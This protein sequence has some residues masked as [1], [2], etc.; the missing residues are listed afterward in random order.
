[1]A[2]SKKPIHNDFF[3]RQFS[4]PEFAVSFFQNHLPKQVAD[5]VDWGNFRLAS[6]DFVSKALKNRKSD[7]LYETTIEDRKSLFYL[8]LEHQRK[9]HKEM[10]FR[11]L[12]YWLHILERHKRQYPKQD[13]PLIFP[14]VLYQGKENWHVAS[15]FHDYLGVPQSLKPYT[16]Q[17]H[18]ALVD[19]SHL[20]DDEI[21]GKLL[22]KL[23]LLIMKHIDAGDIDHLLNSRVLELL[24]E[25]SRSKSGLEHI[26]TLLY[27]LSETSEHIQPEEVIVKLKE[28]PETEE[29]QEVV[30]TLAEKWR[31]EGEQR[32]IEKGIEKGEYLLISMQLKLKFQSNAA[33]YQQKLETASKAQLELIAERILTAPSIESVFEGI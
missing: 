22:V 28:L 3:I 24:F 29:I 14:M 21:Q 33:K 31:E 16:P 10:P 13:L 18:Y 30:M 17:L 4:D 25:L 1:M 15:N 12:S 20:S 2:K 9:P 6:G 8:H 32:G 11:M 19:L 7:L 23:S 26:E 5:Q 27:Y